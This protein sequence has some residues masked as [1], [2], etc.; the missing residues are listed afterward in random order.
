LESA[1]ITHQAVQL[2]RQKAD[3]ITKLNMYRLDQATWQSVPDTAPPGT[4]KVDWDAIDNGTLGKPLMPGAAGAPTRDWLT[5]R[6]FC[7]IAE[8]TARSTVTRWIKG[9][10]LPT[11]R[12]RRPWASDNVPVDESLG[13]NYRRI[14]VPGINELFWRTRLRRESLA[15]TLSHWPREQGWTTKDGEPTPRCHEPIKVSTA[16]LQ[17]AA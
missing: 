1:A 14:W 5:V 17:L 6:E 10:H 12:D 11:R 15:Q 7:E 2:S 4:E 16:P 3:T 8:I 13:V 9:E